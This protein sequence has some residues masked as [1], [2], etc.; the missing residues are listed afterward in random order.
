M[1]RVFLSYAG[2]DGV[3]A[4]AVVAE[5]K[6]KGFDPFWFEDETQRGKPFV[7]RIEAEI[8]AADHF[9]ILMSPSYLSS[10]W[11][12]RE[13]DLAIL[14]ETNLGRQLVW[15]L[16][17]ADTQY[18]ESGLLSTYDWVDLRSPHDPANLSRLLHQ[19][20]PG[21]TPGPAEPA[22]VE[23]PS[24]VFRNRDDELASMVHALTTTGGRDLWLV[25]APPRMGKSW[26]LDQL[27]TEVADRA[28]TCAVRLLDL[29]DHPLDLRVDPVRL[30]GELLDLDAALIPAMP[31]MPLL[32]QSGPA[33]DVAVRAIAA[34]ISRRNRP[35]LYLLD[36]ADLL[37]PAC[38]RRFRSLLT[39]IYHL[40]QRAGN[41]RCRLSVV[42]GSRRQQEWKGLDR[43][44]EPGVR[45][46]PI[47]L[48]EFGVDVVR[49]ALV[50]LAGDRQIGAPQLWECAE[51][52]H[53]LSEGLPALLVRG[54]HWI[55][56][57]QFLQLEESDAEATF[58]VVARP[59]IRDH[60]LSVGSLLPFGGERLAEKKAL[61][62]RALRV[63][64]TYRL[65]TQSHLRYHVEADPGF[66]RA[67]AEVGWTISALWGAVSGTALLRRP[68]E[69]LWHEIHPPIRRLLY[70]YYHDTD[71]AR[72]AAHGSA[73][74]FYE[75]WTEKNAGHEQGVVLVECL[76]HEASRMVA[77]RTGMNGS[78]PGIAADLAST[79]VTS[80]MYEQT[81]FSDFIAERMRGD[82]EFQVALRDVDGLF[83][84]VVESVVTA[85][86]GGA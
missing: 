38:A 74:R 9:V 14:R 80:R 73:R 43:N 81:E 58:D 3:A 71:E 39:S 36:S 57:T 33:S 79:F 51:R 4:R 35:Q 75:G 11:C 66:G 31:P 65:F 44:A 7:S 16:Q 63:L 86:S 22:A 68:L 77:E 82:E 70:R 56:T 12:R 29:R 23:G 50:D 49:Q 5:L 61:L 15:V 69:E 25:I 32:R 41:R 26:L 1:T 76:W 13:R 28:P 78:L 60:L 37:E 54:L 17:V 42:I 30:L 53:R 84:Q 85:I 21:S 20:A 34:E 55:E 6:G 46:H 19:L 72:A 40:V 64:V 2:A 47:A 52:L 48:T 67:L 27:Q 62:E 8:G 24:P 10:A 59:Y 18:A 83:E 45:F